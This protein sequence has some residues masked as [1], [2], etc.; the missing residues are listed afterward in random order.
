MSIA[1]EFEYAKPAG[2]KEALALLARPAP[3]GH[4]RQVRVW[5]KRHDTYVGTITGNTRQAA[6][7]AVDAGPPRTGIVDPVAL[8]PEQAAHPGAPCSTP[9]TAVRSYRSP[10]RACSAAIA[11]NPAPAS[12]DNTVAALETADEALSKVWKS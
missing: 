2:L 4:C 9:R 5:G 11:A 10:S 6:I 1:H 12:F 8:Q 7:C 3:H